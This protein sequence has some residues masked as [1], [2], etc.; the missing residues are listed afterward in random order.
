M[1]WVAQRRAEDGGFEG[2]GLIERE[3]GSTV[4]GVEHG[5]DGEWRLGGEDT[6]EFGGA[7][8]EGVG[9]LTGCDGF[10]N[11]IDQAD[12]QGLGGVDDLAG[13]EEFEGCSATD[14][15]RQALRTAVAGDDAELDLG[16]AEARGRGGEAQGA[17]H[18][19]LA[20]AAEGEAVDD[21]EN[22]LAEGLDAAEDALR[23]FGELLAGGGV[24]LGELGDVRAGGE[25]LAA[26]AAQQDDAHRG[27]EGESGEAADRARAAWWRRA[28]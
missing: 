10:D 15:A 18:G 6:G 26:R 21:G 28:R 16:L 27:V 23:A 19:E 17:G 24:D 13:E 20:A 2:D 12:A 11:F 4:D 3:I 25:G 5:S 22:G 7:G 1:S 8:A 9:T 14:Q